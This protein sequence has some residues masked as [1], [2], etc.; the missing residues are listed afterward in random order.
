MNNSN[1]ETK[2]SWSE[3]CYKIDPTLRAPEKAYVF[4]N[5]NKVFYKFRR[6]SNGNRKK[7]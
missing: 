4:D 5:G 1:K 2:F 7:S 6:K 3:M